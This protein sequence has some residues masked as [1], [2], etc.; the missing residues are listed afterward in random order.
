MYSQSSA[1]VLSFTLINQK[2]FYL[3]IHYD[4]RISIK[5]SNISREVEEVTGKKPTPFTQF[6]KDYSEVFR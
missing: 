2:E 4:R 1:A 5:L 6:A 3:N